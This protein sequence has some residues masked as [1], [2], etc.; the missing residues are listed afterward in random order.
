[1]WE[2]NSHDGGSTSEQAAQRVGG[3]SLLGDFQRSAEE[4]LEQHFKVDLAQWRR[5]D[6]TPSETPS[7]LNFSVLL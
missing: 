1:M 7:D 2:R 6:W 3:I 5:L 4:D